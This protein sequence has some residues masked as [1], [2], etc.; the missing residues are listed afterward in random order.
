MFLLLYQRAQ[1]GVVLFLGVRG[2][3]E[4]GH[5]LGEL[6]IEVGADGGFGGDA[7]EVMLRRGLAGAGHVVGIGRFKPPFDGAAKWF[8]RGCKLDNSKA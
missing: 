3:F 1:V 5:V 6:G 4:L 8:G 2:L 7:G